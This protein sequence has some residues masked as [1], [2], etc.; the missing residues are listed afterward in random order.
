MK[1]NELWF[2]N[3]KDIDNKIVLQHLD[4]RDNRKYFNSDGRSYRVTR[5]AE[6]GMQESPND[7][8]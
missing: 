4:F 1:I 8:F 2:L 3:G 5:T 7:L 6:H